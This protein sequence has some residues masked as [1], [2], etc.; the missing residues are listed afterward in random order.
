ME[1]RWYNLDKKAKKWRQKSDG[2]NETCDKDMLVSALKFQCMSK[3][4]IYTYRKYFIVSRAYSNFF[5]F[6][7]QVYFQID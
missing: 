1:K 6:M 4:P 2:K 5:T 7:L 3:D